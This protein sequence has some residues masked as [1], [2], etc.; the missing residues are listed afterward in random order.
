MYSVSD[1]LNLSSNPLLYWF[2]STPC[3]CNSGVRLSV[4]PA[5]VLFLHSSS[6]KYHIRLLKCQVTI[7]NWDLLLGQSQETKE[8]FKSYGLCVHCSVKLQICFTITC[9]YFCCCCLWLCILL[10][11]V[12]YLVYL[13]AHIFFFFVFRDG[14]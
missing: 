12:L 7:L 5:G 10:R 2:G 14:Q 9:V 4:V 13:L 8:I 11:L 1:D 6:Q 3:T